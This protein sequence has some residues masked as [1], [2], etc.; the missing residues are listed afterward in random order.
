MTKRIKIILILFTLSV[1]LSF[2]SNTYSRYVADTTGNVTMEFANWQI[3]INNEDITNGETSII[4]LTPHIY[5]SAH[6]KENTIAPSSKGYFD[7]TINPENVDVSFE[8][9][10]TLEVLNE[11]MP[12]ILV[13]KYS[14]IEKDTKEEDIKINNIS[15]NTI[16]GYKNIDGSIDGEKQEEETTEPIEDENEEEENTEPTPEEVKEQKIETFTIRVYFEW[17]EGN[18]DDRNEEMNDEADTLVA[19]DEEVDSLEIEAKITFKQKLA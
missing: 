15:E 1:T 12:D 2:M 7:I 6:V 11:N 19:N 17:F 18:T 13:T 16:T 9:N 10:L 4:E 14:I 8:Y 5:K 3:L